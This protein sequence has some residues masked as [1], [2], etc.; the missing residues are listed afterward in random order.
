MP[1]AP[2][3]PEDPWITAFLSY[4]ENE[5]RLSPHTISNY[6]R[7]IHTLRRDSQEA[8]PSDWQQWRNHHVR[9]LMAQQ[10]RNGLGGRS[11]Q[12]KLSALRSFFNYLIREGQIKY[13]PAQGIRAPKTGHH[14]PD[15]LSVDQMQQLLQNSS[16]KPLVTRDITLIELFYS[17]GLRLAELANL[18]LND[19][20]LSQGL[21]KVLGKGS[22]TRILPIG[23]MAQTALKNWL[24][25]R[26]QYA[27]TD[28]NALF[29]ARN[30]NRLSHRSIQERIKILSRKQGLTGKIHPHMLRH[31]FAS[32]LLESSGDL[33]AV[34][35]LLG[36][37]NINTTQIYT[38]LNFQH[39]AQS[40]DQAHPRARKK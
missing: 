39:L 26:A 7:D 33:R 20:D 5:R 22:K 11:I 37:S 23:R 4:M 34:Q 15:T 16:N 21:V 14:L 31:S 40:Y 38:H 2:I 27:N 9:H 1:A 13:N 36:H 32:H 28:N 12:R 25:L 3:R 10:H 6:Q 30:G 19:I 18:D 35:E 17:S 24:K 29:V 8:L